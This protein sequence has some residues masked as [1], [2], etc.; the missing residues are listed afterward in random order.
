MK[1]HPEVIA[2]LLLT[3]FS[4]VASAVRINQIRNFQVSSG[5]RQQVS[6]PG[7]SCARTLPDLL[8]KPGKLKV[9]LLSV[10]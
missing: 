4:M 10:M 8:P 3:A 7:V 5:L 1:R 9:R 6:A 2:L